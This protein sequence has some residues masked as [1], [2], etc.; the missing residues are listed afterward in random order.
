MN[1]NK[2]YLGNTLSSNI[3]MCKAKAYVPIHI[4]EE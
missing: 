4:T 1:A 3:E 2:D